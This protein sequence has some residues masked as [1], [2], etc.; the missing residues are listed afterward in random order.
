M[1]TGSGLVVRITF[2]VMTSG[3]LIN[4][5]AISAIPNV[6]AIR[7]VPHLVIHGG[8]RLIMSCNSSL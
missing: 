8:I 7:V 1:V 5:A 3:Y 6:I 2:P 4:Q